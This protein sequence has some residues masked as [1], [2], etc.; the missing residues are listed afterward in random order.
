MR[1]TPRRV[2]LIL[3]CLIVAACGFPWSARAANNPIPFL[4]TPLVPMT[5]AP[6]GGAFTLTVNGTGFVSGATVNWNGTALT[7]TSVSSSQLT[8]AVPATNIATAGTAWITVTNP[9]PGGGTSNIAYLG[10]TNPASALAFVT[11]GRNMGLAD[12][13]PCGGS[14][15]DYS[16]G[17]VFAAADFN[18]DARLDLAIP[19]NNGNTVSVQLGN[20]DGTFATAT[21]YA[22]GNNPNYVLVGDFNGD[23]KLDLAVANG[24]DT[25]VSVLLGNGDGTFQNA[26][27]VSFGTSSSPPDPL[28]LAAGDFNGDGKLDL[29]LASQVGGLFIFLGNGDGT[30]QTPVSYQDGAP[31]FQDLPVGIVTADFNRDGKLDLI[32]AMST[33]GPVFHPPADPG[34]TIL[35]GNGDGTFQAATSLNL[36]ESGPIQVADLNGDG[37][38]DLIVSSTISNGSF[39]F[40]LG[41]GDGTFQTSSA[42]FD[43]PAGPEGAAP[44]GD[45]NGDGKLDA[46]SVDAGT[47]NLWVM[48]GNGDG[49]FPVSSNLSV[50]APPGAVVAGD[51]NGDGKLDFVV[52]GT[53]PGNPTIAAPTTLLQGSFPILT[54]TPSALS[55]G[56]QQVGTSSAGQIVLLQ[57][58]GNTSLSIAQITTSGDFAETD[59]CGT[60]MLGGD[61]CQIVVIFT[62]TGVG[63]RTGTLTIAD[64][65]A[66]NP[67]VVP[68]TGTGQVGSPSPPSPPSFGPVISL[69][70]ATVTF[71][72]QYVGTSGLPQTVT[73][74]NTGTAT[75]NIT[76]VVASVADFGVL[77]NCSNPV[78][79]G[80]SCTIGVFFDPTTGGT[81]T[82]TLNLT[83]NASG[84]PQTVS[85]TGTG[86]GFSM[87][88]GASATATVS[89]GQTATYAIAVA[90]AGGFAHT[91]AL[92]CGGG[93]SGSS[94]SVSPSSL[95]LNGKSSQTATVSVTTAASG[96]VLPFGIWPTSKN[97]RTTPLVVGTMTLFLLTLAAC[98]ARQREQRVG[99]APAFAIVLVVCLGLTIT[100]CGGGSSSGGGGG[101]GAQSGTYTI[102]VT[103]AYT[104]GSANVSSSTKLTLVVQ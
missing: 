66:G 78:A 15:D 23:G 34:G 84:S 36:A 69:S 6:G 101:S 91:V 82:G 26:Q 29:A 5:V 89:A 70:P 60:S 3:S 28:Y 14:A 46:A 30:F 86:E 47:G 104:S 98:L 17:P 57:N 50:V 64:N 96:S 58:G 93:P 72:G 10:I 83:D 48:L 13:T 25:S 77:S 61:A 24:G 45:I 11:I 21:D 81:R 76:K 103:G 63:N 2:C 27:T 8:A 7:T 51:F 92:T 94:C 53:S 74:T 97:L 44:L 12:S 43:S 71:S 33:I 55:F 67:H 20:G 62:P 54:V 75:L 32:V 39:A 35:L 19:Q 80:A 1:L 87:A 73:V 100:S 22:V 31:T 95:A 16:C 18:G 4:N 49:T 42:W 52:V 59:S 102:T 41:N 85:L 65:A 90:P 56:A 37:K 40:V 88:A 68:L 38:L 79:V 99:R 9:A